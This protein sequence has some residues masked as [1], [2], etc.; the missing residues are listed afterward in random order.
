VTLQ[1]NQVRDTAG[2][3]AS[4]AV[5]GTFQVSLIYRTYLPFMAK[6]AQP[7]LVAKISL[8]PNKRTFAAG[9]PVVVT[10]TVTNQGTGPTVGFWVD[11]Y[12]NPAAPPTAANMTWNTTCALSPCYGIAWYVPGPLAPGASITLSSA[13]GMPGYTIWPGYFAAGTTDLYVYV[14]SWNPSA[15]TGAV[16]EANETNNSDHIGGLTV[17]GPNPAFRGAPATVLPDRPTHLRR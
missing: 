14:D 16:L 3:S 13:S 12:I 2:N 1:P 10:V 8:V 7:D 5:L 4:G 9:E 17:T 11:L 15:A 6:P